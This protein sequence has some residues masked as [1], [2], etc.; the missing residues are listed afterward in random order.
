MTDPTAQRTP[1]ADLIFMQGRGM[2]EIADQAGVARQT[3][4]RLCSGTHRPTRRTAERIARV[5]GTTV[6]E[7][8]PNIYEPIL[9]PNVGLAT[10]RKPV[11]LIERTLR[12]SALRGAIVYDPFGG[13]GSTMVA[14]E[15]LGMRARLMELDPGYCDVIRDRYTTYTGQVG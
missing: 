15:T 9:R 10:A 14:A 6:E 7:V 11:E 4:T 5:L 12:N 13:S 1:L 2:G 3:M 8:V